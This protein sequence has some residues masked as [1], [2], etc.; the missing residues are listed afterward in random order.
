MIVTNLN[1]TNEA[2]LNNAKV[3]GNLNVSGTIVGNVIGNANINTLSSDVSGNPINVNSQLI[4]NNSLRPIIMAIA[5]GSTTCPI[6]DLAGNTFPSDKYIC[7][8]VYSNNYIPA[9]GIKNNKWWIGNSLWDNWQLC[10]LEFTPISYYNIK[11]LFKAD[12]QI[13]ASDGTQLTNSDWIYTRGNTWINN[14]YYV[15]DDKGVPQKVTP[16][17]S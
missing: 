8:V 2:I 11:S 16:A 3:T 5:L 10:V 1:A 4:Y 13:V 17:S 6:T 7:K 14:G 9:L 12:S 15:F